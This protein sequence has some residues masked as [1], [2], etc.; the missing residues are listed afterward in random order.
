MEMRAVSSKIISEIGY[1]EDQFTL[2][3]KFANGGLYHYDD[4]SPEVYSDLISAPSVGGYFLKE[5]KAKYAAHKVG[6]G[7]GASKETTSPGPAILEEL[8]ENPQELKRVAV[9][10]QQKVAAFAINSPEHYVQAAEELNIVVQK[11][12][13]AQE[14]IDRLKKPAY[15]AYREVL[16]LEKEVMAPY[17]AAERH[18]KDGIAAY[19]AEEERRRHTEERRLQQEAQKR[20]EEEARKRAEEAAIREAEIAEAQGDT[21]AA[22]AILMAPREVIPAFVPAVVL[23]KEVPQVENIDA[24]KKWKYRIV[25]ESL[26]PRAYLLINE[27]AI[28]KVVRAL[29]SK[30]PE[31][32]PGIE[33][34][35]EDII[36][37]R[38]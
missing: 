31:I 34:Y 4:V 11:R 8:T 30:A 7:N 20:A 24:T 5:I 33:V 6:N 9:E 19:R 17:D 2:A 36:R 16:E 3:V 26:I 28:G 12:K 10:F 23:P 29:K 37:V 35:S 38:S 32:I 21:A 22:E 15:K 27:V 13:Q 14:R 18:L 1:D 25:D